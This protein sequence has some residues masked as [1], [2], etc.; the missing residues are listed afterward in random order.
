MEAPPKL[1]LALQELPES[2]RRFCDT[3]GPTPLRMMAAR[4]G[5]P[6]RGIELVTMLAQLSADPDPQVKGTAEKTLADLPD[7]VLLPACQGELHPSVLDLLAD[8]RKE[9]D[10]VLLL[11]VANSRTADATIQKT[12][13]HASEPVCE[14]IAINEQRLLKAPA[15]IEALYMNRNTRMSTADR[16]V[17]LA[18]RNDI[19][20]TGIPAFGAHLEAVKEQLIPEPTPEPLPSD[21]AFTET[22]EDY[23]WDDTAFEIDDADGTETLKDEGKPLSMRIKD[24]TQGEKIRLAV[25]GSSGARALLVRDPD[26]AVSYAA[27]SSPSMNEEEAAAVAMSRD[28]GDHVLRYI[29][30][31]R[32][33]LRNYELKRALVFNPKTPVGISMKFMSH[34]RQTELKRLAHSKEVASQVRSVAAQ[35]LDRRQKG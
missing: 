19:E 17:E 26:K 35:W 9:Q 23:D 28:I 8:T 30:N 6:V 34:L 25:I 3:K 22:L 16:L 31:K 10:N 5:M 33:W 21:L 12:A 20:L 13:R 2:I 24:M 18:G 11:I 15:I 29:G 14:R 1:P 7:N 32:E 27:I 4:G